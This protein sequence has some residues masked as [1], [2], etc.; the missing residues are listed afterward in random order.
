MSS[1]RAKK[2]RRELRRLQSRQSTDPNV[3][4]PEEFRQLFGGEGVE[5]I[6]E[7]LIR[8]LVSRGKSESD[9]RAFARLG[10]QYSRPRDS[11]LSPLERL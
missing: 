10:F 5:P 11:F 6:T 8:E 3:V 7:S 2:Q 4:Q 1:G 9:V